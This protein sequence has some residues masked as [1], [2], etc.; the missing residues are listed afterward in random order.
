MWWGGCGRV[1]ARLSSGQ[2]SPGDVQSSE[3]AFEYV[4]YACS[5]LTYLDRPLRPDLLPLETQMHG[6]V[7]AAMLNLRGR[8][9]WIFR[10]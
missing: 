1:V 7:A 10:I 6:T 8:N 5:R 3:S 2:C 4:F 9:R